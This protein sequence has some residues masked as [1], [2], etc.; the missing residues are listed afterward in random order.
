MILIRHHPA[1]RL[2]L[3][4]AGCLLII[5]LLGPDSLAAAPMPH[6]RAAR[7]KLPHYKHIVIVIE[8]NHSYSNILRNPHA[9]YINHL[10]HIGANF[11]HAFAI[12]HPSQPNYLD[13][14]SGSNQNVHNDGRPDHLPFNSP[15]LGAQLL[16]LHL[17]FIG[18][19]ETMPRIGFNGN[20]YKKYARKHNPWVNW[21]NNRPG[22]YQLPPTVNRP[23]T[24]WPKDFNKLPDVALVIPNL[25]HDMHDGTIRAGDVWLHNHLAPYITWA[26]THD[27]LFILTFDEDD[28]CSKNHIPTLFVGQHVIPG[29]DPTPINHFAVLRTVEDLKHLSHLGQAK[30]AKTITSCFTPQ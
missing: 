9:P 26:R 23:F 15:N 6:A 27:S 11:T 19:A 18:Y 16:A 1:V 2:C 14:F 5:A 4:A 25:N 12:E 10:A 17:T 28:Y 3:L 30:T 13:L 24:D 8:E 7:P 20:T 29:N 21:Q 22:K